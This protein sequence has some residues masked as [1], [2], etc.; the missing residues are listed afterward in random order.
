VDG[1]TVATSE[2][3]HTA[4]LLDRL[5]VALDGVAPGAHLVALKV[6]SSSVPDAGRVR[7]RL[8]DGAGKP[9]ALATSADLAGVPEAP[10][11]A[12]PAPTARGRRPVAPKAPF[13]VRRLPTTL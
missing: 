10:P 3:Q 9:L 4:M 12:P 13:T 7:V 8:S 11:P 2:D 1:I 5:A 6:C